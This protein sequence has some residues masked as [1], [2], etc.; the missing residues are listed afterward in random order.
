VIPAVTKYRPPAIAT[1]FDPAKTQSGQ[2]LSNGNL[3]IAA[4]TAPSAANRGTQST[5][6]YSSGKRY[7]EF[8]ANN[9]T[10]GA[11]N[12]ILFLGLCDSACNGSLANSQNLA[13][14]NWDSGYEIANNS[15][16]GSGFGGY[17]AGDVIGLA[18]DMSSSPTVTKYYK[19]NT[20]MFT[21]TA[22]GWVAP[23]FI[24][25]AAYSGTSTLAKVTVNFGATS[26]VY[27][28][29]AGFTGGW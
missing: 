16:V 23:F 27:S 7:I 3:T 2:T 15:V 25:A 22:T 8:T 10:A 21:H 4:T 19:N 26:F 1:T 24:F 14:G 13:Y 28:P 12:N 9:A 18:V 17:Q 5:V 29:P 20:L 6:G 11:L